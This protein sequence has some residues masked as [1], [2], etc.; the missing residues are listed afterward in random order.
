LDKARGDVYGNELLVKMSHPQQKRN[1]KQK[2]AGEE[3]NFSDKQLERDLQEAFQ[4][5]K[6]PR[7][8]KEWLPEIRRFSERFPSANH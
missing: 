5:K 4:L 7:T 6:L 2:T 1:Q 8:R 3:L